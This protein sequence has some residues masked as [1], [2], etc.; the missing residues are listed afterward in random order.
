[1]TYSD[2]VPPTPERGAG[3]TAAG[4]RQEPPR[5]AQPVTGPVPADEPTGASSP[6]EPGT[7]VVL[8]SPSKR[9]ELLVAVSSA[10]LAAG[11]FALSR[12]IPVVVETGGIDPR[13]WPSVLTG[14]WF[15]LSLV[16]LVW[17]LR[18]PVPR[19]DLESTT[20]QGW[21]RLLLLTLLS[22]AF[23]AVWPVVGFPAA[24]LVFLALVLWVCGARSW[25][26]LVIYPVAT[27]GFIYLLFH[28]LLRV[29]L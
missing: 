29:P 7:E 2:P 22:A 20:A 4:S 28:S 12:A 9:L 11:W 10:V 18:A 14:T 17:A 21:R 8:A 25:K 5:S 15:A 3:G 13:W 27:T 16:L 6:A 1:M 19:D 26:T 24:S 23:V